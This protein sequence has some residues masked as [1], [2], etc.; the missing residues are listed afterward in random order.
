MPSLLPQHVIR[1]PRAAA[2]RDNA[3][4]LLEDVFARGLTDAATPLL[5][6]SLCSAVTAPAGALATTVGAP[7][8][9]PPLLQL[10]F[11]VSIGGLLSHAVTATTPELVAQRKLPMSHTS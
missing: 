4:G 11:V 10:G 8:S 2:W 9:A 1:I 7:V 6:A 5:D 3:D